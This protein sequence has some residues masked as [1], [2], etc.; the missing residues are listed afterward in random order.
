MHWR[1]ATSFSDADDLDDSKVAW[2]LCVAFNHLTPFCLP[3][4]EAHSFCR[5]EIRK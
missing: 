5:F 3:L 2:I 1:K 4:T